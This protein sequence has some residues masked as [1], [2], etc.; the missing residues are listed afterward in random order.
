MNSNDV[1]CLNAFHL[2]WK[3]YL[4]VYGSRRN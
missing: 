2:K 1:N 3:E 4:Y